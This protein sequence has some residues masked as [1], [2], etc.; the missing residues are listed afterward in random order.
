M[1]AMPPHQCDAVSVTRFV[2]PHFV[3]CPRP[4]RSEVR[5]SVPRGDVVVEAT[6]VCIAHVA[7]AGPEPGSSSSGGLPQQQVFAFL[8][9][10]SYGLRLVV[11]VSRL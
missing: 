4:C 6:Q 8:P 9:L 7:G 1:H 11:Q 5:P 3:C 2:Y 10:R